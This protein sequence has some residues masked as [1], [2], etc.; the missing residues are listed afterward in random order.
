[1]SQC[2]RK[3]VDKDKLSLFWFF[4]F[5]NDDRE[6]MLAQGK[7]TPAFVTNC[8]LPTVISFDRYFHVTQLTCLASTFLSNTELH[9]K[10]AIHQSKVIIYS[11]PKCC[12]FARDIE[13]KN[14]RI[15]YLCERAEKII[16]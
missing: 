7:L 8:L 11:N 14:M 12:Y 1:M 4:L 5:D 16:I 6:T 10:K 13:L 15:W 2:M 9:L 3:E